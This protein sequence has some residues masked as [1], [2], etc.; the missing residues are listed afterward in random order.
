MVAARTQADLDLV[1]TDLPALPAAD[2]LAPRSKA[3]R[4]TIALRSDSKQIGRWR[5]GNRRNVVSLMGDVTLDLTT[6][7]FAGPEIVVTAVTLTGDIELVVPVGMQVE[8][9][10]VQLLGDERLGLGDGPP[11]PGLP[12]LRVRVYALMGDVTVRT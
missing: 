12:L 6:A 5:V 2:T 11:L 10:G 7:L 9:S 8:M 3:S 4:W 1:T